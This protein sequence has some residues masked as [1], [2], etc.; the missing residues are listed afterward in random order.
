MDPAMVSF[1]SYVEK[2]LMCIYI[3]SSVSQSMSISQSYPTLCLS[4]SAFDFLI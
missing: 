2:T 3:L 1:V 4:I